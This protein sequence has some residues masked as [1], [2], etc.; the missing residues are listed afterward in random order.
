MDC[1]GHRCPVTPHWHITHGKSRADSK[2][3]RN[4][5]DIFR[6]G[7]VGRDSFVSD[8]LKR[9]LQGRRAWGWH[10]SKWVEVIIRLQNPNEKNP[11]GPFGLGGWPTTTIFIIRRDEKAVI[12]SWVSP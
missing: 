4:K 7:D 12:R 8:S 1:W 11:L 6:E 5:P 3:S 2:Q 9:L 10:K